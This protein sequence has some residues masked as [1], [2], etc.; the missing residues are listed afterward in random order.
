MSCGAE[1]GQATMRRVDSGLPL[2]CAAQQ[3]FGDLPRGGKGQ[4]L[5][6]VGLWPVPVAVERAVE[7]LF[8]RAER[9]VERGSVDVHRLAEVGQRRALVPEPPEDEDGA[10]ERFVDVELARATHQPIVYR[11]VQ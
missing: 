8:L 1:Y 3:R 11:A 2:D 6:L 4:C 5:R 10:V 9:G 7:E